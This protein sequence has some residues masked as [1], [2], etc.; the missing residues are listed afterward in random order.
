MEPEQAHNSNTGR[1][2][3]GLGYEALD[4]WDY[5]ADLGYELCSFDERGEILCAAQRPADFRNAQNLVAMKR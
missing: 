4:I 5:L 1:N 2:T 3:E